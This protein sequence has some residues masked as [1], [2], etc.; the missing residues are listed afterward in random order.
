[1]L[2]EIQPQ[3]AE[4]GRDLVQE[5]EPHIQR[6]TPIHS[7]AI[8]PLHQSF[9]KCVRVP[10]IYFRTTEVLFKTQIPGPHLSHT[11]SAYLD[12]GPGDLHF[13]FFFRISFLSNLNT[14]RGAPTY[15]PEIKS[16]TLHLLSLPGTPGGLHF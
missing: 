3:N 11:E 10:G 1:M 15:K 2:T 8:C 16:R 4:A 12:M 13:F 5:L 7:S 6:K 14:H 9:S